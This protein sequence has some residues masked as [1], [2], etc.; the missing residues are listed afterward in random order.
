MTAL[1][2][3]IQ[4]RQ[5]TAAEWALENPTLL[6]GEFG[7]ESDTGKAKLGDGTTAWNDL[8]YY[9]TPNTIRKRW[10][11]SNPADVP[12]ILPSGWTAEASGLQHLSPATEP[13]GPVTYPNSK[14]IRFTSIVGSTGELDFSEFA[15]I[16]DGSLLEWTICFEIRCVD[17]W[18]GTALPTWPEGPTEIFD[19]YT[20]AAGD[21]AGAYLEGANSFP[22]MLTAQYSLF[23]SCYVWS[24]YETILSVKD[25][26]D[27]SDNFEARF[28]ATLMWPQNGYEVVIY[29]LELEARM[30]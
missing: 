20:F 4:N 10:D 19:A 11:F 29:W 3:P 26:H 21:V 1:E 17:G 7:V 28:Y 2:G 23:L 24:Y 16:P 12:L 14:N 6:V 27:A 5:G 13:P 9:G 8:G 30:P 18:N 22:P 15:G 25:F